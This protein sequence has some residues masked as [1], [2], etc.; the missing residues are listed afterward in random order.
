[1]TAES[2]LFSHP[3]IVI[4]LAGMATAIVLG[5]LGIISGM[6]VSIHRQ[7]TNARLKEQMIERDFTDEEIEHLTQ[8]FRDMDRSFTPGDLKRYGKAFRKS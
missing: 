3:E 8:C 2:L 6:A 7:N 5:S 4:P 1:M